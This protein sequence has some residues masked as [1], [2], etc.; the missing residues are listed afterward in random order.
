MSSVNAIEV[1]AAATEVIR[2]SKI[3][4]ITSADYSE[5]EFKDF[6][7]SIVLA[8]MSIPSDHDGGNHGLAGSIDSDAG[9]RALLGSTTATF[10][11]TAKPKSDGPAIKESDTPAQVATAT[12]KHNSQSVA[13]YTELGCLKGLKEVIIENVPAEALTA[14]EDETYGLANVSAKDMLAHLESNCSP[15]DCFEV[16]E[17]L[18]RRDAAIDFDS[19][20]SLKVY[21]TNLGRLLKTL[22]RHG[23]KTSVSELLVRH[24]SQFKQQGEFKDEVTE[25]ETMNQSL[26]TWDNFKKH[27]IDADHAR[28]L[29][30]KYTNKTA[31]ST[32]F[33]SANNVTTMDEL[34]NSLHKGL[35]GIAEAADETIKETVNAAIADKFKSLP[36]DDNEAA[37]KAAFSKEMEG[38]RTKLKAVEEENKKLKKKKGRGQRYEQPC[39]HCENV[40]VHISEERCW[41]NPKNKDK[42]PEGWTPKKKE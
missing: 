41:G 17:L 2:R 15:T 31:G 23:V 37:W 28:R 42:A 4:P 13:Y 19:E 18:E 25:W 29:R 32:G 16:E 26:R 39:K 11:P 40:H 34:Y 27:F 33:G 38:L 5:R 7:Q 35:S 6:K 8:A 9:Y 36:K 30:N 1:M 10:T 3:S 12:A 22:T 24:L 21:Y 14:L 20:D